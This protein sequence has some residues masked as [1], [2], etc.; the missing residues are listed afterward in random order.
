MRPGDRSRVFYAGAWRRV[1]LL[2]RSERGLF[3]HFSGDGDLGG[4]DNGRSITRRALEK[5]ASAGLVQPLETRT[6]VQRSAERLA[7]DATPS[8]G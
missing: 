1:Q 8:A 6:L 3:F 4:R 2:W 7:R 5:A